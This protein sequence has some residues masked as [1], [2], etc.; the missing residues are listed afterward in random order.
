MTRTKKKKKTRYFIP[1]KGVTTSAI[2]YLVEKNGETY[3]FTKNDGKLRAWWS[4][5]RLRTF[6]KPIK[7]SRL[8]LFL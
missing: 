1:K 4:I 3:F 7:K 6:A 5:K 2:Y 8:A